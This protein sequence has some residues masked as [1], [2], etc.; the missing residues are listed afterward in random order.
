MSK[1]ILNAYRNGTSTTSPGNLFLCPTN[2]PYL[3][4][5]PTLFLFKTTPPCPVTT[6]P[7]KKSFSIFLVSSLYILRKIFLEPSLLDEQLQFCFFHRRS[8][9]WSFSWPNSTASFCTFQVLP[10]PPPPTHIHQTK[11]E[12]LSAVSQTQIGAHTLIHMHW[13]AST[14]KWTEIFQSKQFILTTSVSSV[15]LQRYPAY[16]NHPGWSPEED[17][18]QHPAHASPFKSTWTSWSVM[19]TSSSFH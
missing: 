16:W 8:A 13:F 5:K 6:G 1:L 11:A 3:Q 4:S 18:K 7:C 17:S 10:T 15:L 14:A 9:L 19:F 2:L 12:A